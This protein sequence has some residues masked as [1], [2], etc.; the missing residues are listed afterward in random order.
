MVK[1]LHNS[2]LMTNF[3]SIAKREHLSNFE[4]TTPLPVKQKSFE[5]AREKEQRVPQK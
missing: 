2:V 3:E 1:T 5:R 4:E